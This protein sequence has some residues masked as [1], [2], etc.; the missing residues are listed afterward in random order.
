MI[1]LYLVLR[2]TA[3]YTTFDRNDST[4]PGFQPPHDRGEFRIRSGLRWGGI[5]PILFPALA[6]ELCVWY[7]RRFRTDSGAY[8]FYSQ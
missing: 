2:G 7:E 3:H 5:E 1:P 6:M 8:H 4:A